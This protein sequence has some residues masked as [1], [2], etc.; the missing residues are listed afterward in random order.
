MVPAVGT[1]ERTNAFEK[2][3]SAGNAG[4]V[5]SVMPGAKIQVALGMPDRSAIQ[6]SSACSYNVALTGQFDG[7][8][9]FRQTFWA[10]PRNIPV[11]SETAQVVSETNVMVLISA[12]A[13]KVKKN[14][15]VPK[16]NA[17]IIMLVRFIVC[18]L[19]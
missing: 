14:N 10:K 4:D 19:L 16:S 13:D 17:L 12:A 3:N 18:S 11:G 5:L 7:T 15:E 2:E 6:A 1:L 8:E 9:A